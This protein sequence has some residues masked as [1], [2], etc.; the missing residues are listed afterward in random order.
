MPLLPYAEFWANAMS[1]FFLKAYL[2]T[3]EGSAFVPN[4]PNDLSIML[5]TYMLERAVYDLNYELNHR[6]KWVR[7]ALHL[8]Q[9]IV[10]EK[11]TVSEEVATV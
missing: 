5:E 3:T 8:I 4:D 9:S 2:E 6:P 1:S 11:E 7:I 10:D